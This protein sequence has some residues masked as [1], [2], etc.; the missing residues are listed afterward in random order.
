MTPVIKLSIGNDQTIRQFSIFDSL[1]IFDLVKKQERENCRFCEHPLNK[2]AHFYQHD[3]GW[4]VDTI[5]EKIW[6]WF[7]C[8]HCHH[9]WSLTHLGVSR[10]VPIKL[11]D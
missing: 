2:I 1:L 7:E 3:N 9:Q 6:I 5:K 10:S 4:T 11:R 8:S